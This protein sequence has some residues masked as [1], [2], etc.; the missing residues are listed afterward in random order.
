MAFWNMPQLSRKRLTQ[1]LPL[2]ILIPLWAGSFVVA[3]FAER[4]LIEDIHERLAVTL[5]A[6]QQHLQTVLDGQERN[7]TLFAA[8]AIRNRVRS[9]SSSTVPRLGW[10]YL[11]RY[12]PEA[13]GCLAFDLTGRLVAHTGAPG[14]PPPF[15][16]REQVPVDLT[17]PRVTDPTT[18]PTDPSGRSTY[19]IFFPLIASEENAYGALVGTLVCR[20]TNI[21][22]QTLTE[23][24]RELGETGEVYLV[25]V[26]TG[27]MLTGSR[28][29]LNV[30]G[31]VK[32][33]TVGV[34]QALEAGEGRA[35][36]ADYRG[37]PVMGVSLALPE[38][39]WVLLAEMDEAEALAPV[40]R[41]RV[42]LGGSVALV[43]L[44]AGLVGWWYGRQVEESERIETEL[45]IASEIQ[46]SILPR[47]FP[48][49]PNRDEFE[50]YAETIPAREMGGDFYDF[51]LLDQERLG[52]VIADVS[53]KGVPAAVFMAVTCTI[54]RATALQAS[55]P[56][57][58]LSRVNNLLCPENDSAMFVTVFY[59]ILNTRTGDLEY[60]NAGHNLPYVL[61]ARG[62]VSMLETP[63]GTAL[64]VIPDT[65]YRLKRI[66]L[67]P[68]DGLFLYTD[69][70]TEA[71]D[72]KGTL[73]T[74]E[75]LRQLLVKIQGNTP[76]EL[77]RGTVAEVRTHAAGE[78]QADDITLLALRY[79]QGNK[80]ARRS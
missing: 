58:C 21:L 29:M 54:L 30:I 12:V 8:G 48:P 66:R 11:S 50:L 52:L 4:A 31:R 36:Y 13:M 32:V 42:V 40:G 64:G 49:F 74:D 55:S 20:V 68:G 28:F 59:G 75:R 71:M 47:I 63:G 17:E 15:A 34:R 61:S 14:Q 69:G 60:S 44:A 9:P 6:Y 23:P 1:W 5:H 19:D 27:L 65:P 39:G 77:V 22:S 35:L 76:L 41:L 45:G 72:S 37:I 78:P 7:L 25:S 24:R 51:F 56:S 53:G 80:G 2:L 67:R 73:F 57:E 43:S 18:D 46:R 3:H 62:S 26:K 70:V 38:Y 10:D 79:L 33:D 16:V